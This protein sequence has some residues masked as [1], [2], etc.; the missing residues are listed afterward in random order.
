MI[1]VLSEELISLPEAASLVPGRGTGK[2]AD[3][4][5]LYRWADVGVRGVRLETIPAGTRLCTSREAMQRF[6]TALE[7]RRSGPL[8]PAEDAPVARSE[9]QRQRDSERAAR[10]LDGLMRGRTTQRRAASA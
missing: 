6:F 1:D 10:R 5:T 7:A 4:K 9:A 8:A 2:T 3:P